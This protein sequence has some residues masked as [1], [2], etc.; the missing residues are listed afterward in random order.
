MG[1]IH[2]QMLPKALATGVQPQTPSNSKGARFWRVSVWHV[3]LNVV[4]KLFKNGFH[5]H[6]NTPKTVG[7][8]GSAPDPQ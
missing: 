5:L 2:T 3:D 7:G 1:S 4:L 8:W 6:P